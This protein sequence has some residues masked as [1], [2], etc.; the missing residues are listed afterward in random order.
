[1]IWK[2]L[3]TVRTFLP[4]QGTGQNSNKKKETSNRD[5]ERVRMVKGRNWRRSWRGTRPMLLVGGMREIIGFQGRGGRGAVEGN[6][7][8]ANELNQFFNR[9][10]SIMDNTSHPLCETVNILR[11][12]FCNWLIQPCSQMK[13]IDWGWRKNPTAPPV[14]GAYP[15]EPLFVDLVPHWWERT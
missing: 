8:R 15:E 12:S 9:F 13:M 7:Q 6:A 10:D 3:P 14:K 1:M 4:G 5:S 2:L 11:S